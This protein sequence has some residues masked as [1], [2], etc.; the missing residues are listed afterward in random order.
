MGAVR[1]TMLIL[2]NKKKCKTETQRDHVIF[3]VSLNLKDLL[4][5]NFHNS[6]A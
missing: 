1:L 5:T 3:P 6:D 2:Q 4:V